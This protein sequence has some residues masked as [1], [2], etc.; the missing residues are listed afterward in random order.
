MYGFIATA[1]LLATTARALSVGS[2]VVVNGCEYNVYLADVP[3]QPSNGTEIDKTLAPGATFT[4]QW[5]ELSNLAGWSIKLSKDTTFKNI[6]QYEYTF[7]N[8]GIIWYDL[9]DVDGNPWDSNWEI[10]AE[11][12]SSVCA[13]KQQ[14]Y[15]Y[16][17][18]DAY[19]MQAC[20]QDA[21]ITVLLCSGE[22]QNDGDTSAASSSVAALSTS[23]ASATTTTAAATTSTSSTSTKSTTTRNHYHGYNAVNADDSSSATTFATSTTAVSS[24]TI[25]TTTTGGVTVTEVETAVVTDIVYATAYVNSRVKRNEAALRHQHHARHGHVN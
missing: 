24:S 13:P 23:I 14:A 8:D 11:C 16:S 19:G 22:S 5:T 1:A 7:Q 21:V 9:S 18:D 25:T 2:A 20:A 17:T 6:M 4:Q 12:A 3:S 10:T 15:R